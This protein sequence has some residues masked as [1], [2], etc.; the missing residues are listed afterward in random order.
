MI[1]Q[2]NKWLTAAKRGVKD[3]VGGGLQQLPIV[4]LKLELPCPRITLIKALNDFVKKT[5]QLSGI[6]TNSFPFPKQAVSN[7]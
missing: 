3:V 7:H 5:Y 6:S 4:L 1:F 2:S